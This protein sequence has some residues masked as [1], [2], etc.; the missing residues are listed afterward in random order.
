MRRLFWWIAVAGWILA[1]A[2]WLFAQQPPPTANSYTILGL[3]GARIQDRARVEPGNVGTNRGTFHLGARVQ[4]TGSVAADTVRARAGTQSEHFFCLLGIGPVICEPLSAPVVDAASLPLVQVMPGAADIRVPAGANTTPLEAGAY[5][6]ARVGA[7]GRLTLAGGDYTMRSLS[8]APRG[9]LLCAAPCHVSVLERVIVRQR[10]L[11]GATA[12]YGAGD[13]SIQ[14]E[15][16]DG[17]PVF[18]A[19]SPSSVAASVYAPNGNIILGAD[20]TY[21]GRFIGRTIRVGQRARVKGLE[22]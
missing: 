5:G 15:A 7:R 2:P 20:G 17:K 1:A 8:I 19:R 14:V 18:S 13:V 22:N 12:P 3:E 21:E 11:I 6:V 4:I 10:A 16:D 9:R